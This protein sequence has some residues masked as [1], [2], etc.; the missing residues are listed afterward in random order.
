MKWLGRG[1]RDI[2]NY[3]PIRVKKKAS[4]KLLISNHVTSMGYDLVF[5]SGFFV[6]S[7]VSLFNGL[8]KYAYNIIGK[9]VYHY[10]KTPTKKQKFSKMNDTAK[11]WKA[12]SPPS[13]EYIT[14][15]TISTTAP[16]HPPPHYSYN[17]VIYQALSLT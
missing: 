3:Q 9:V 13:L 1:G 2:G 6:T 17:I 14:S 8:I 4:I 16:L 15:K 10:Q 12:P 11:R 5:S 7:R